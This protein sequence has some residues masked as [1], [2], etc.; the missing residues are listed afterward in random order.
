VPSSILFL[1]LQSTAVVFDACRLLKPNG[2]GELSLRNRAVVM[3]GGVRIRM[4]GSVALFSLLLILVTERAAKY[5][6]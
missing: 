3:F 2:S 6:H 5:L 1:R 4:A